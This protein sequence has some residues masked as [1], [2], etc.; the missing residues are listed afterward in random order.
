MNRSV[1]KF[2]DKETRK[3]GLMLNPNKYI[4]GEGLNSLKLSLLGATPITKPWSL[5]FFSP[6][7]IAIH[8]FLPLSWYSNT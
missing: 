2:Y 8:G 7:S 5:K 1:V 6:Q 4:F 3:T